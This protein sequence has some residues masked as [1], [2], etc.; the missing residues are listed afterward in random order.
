MDGVENV[1][2]HA[3]HLDAIDMNVVGEPVIVV[4]HGYDLLT[5]IKLN[6][7]M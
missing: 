2:K 4:V 3:M 6:P 5:L 1:C 7:K